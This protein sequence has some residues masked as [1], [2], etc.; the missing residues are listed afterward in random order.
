MATFLNSL[1]KKKAK[2]A[3]EEQYGRIASDVQA[4]KMARIALENKGDVDVQALENKGAVDVTNLQ[5]TGSTLRTNITDT[6]NTLRRNLAE[7]G[8]TQRTGMNL[9]EDARQFDKDYGLNVKKDT[10]E[11][12]QFDLEQAQAEY[13]DPFERE[14]RRSQLEAEVPA[15][16]YSGRQSY[17]E[18]DEMDAEEAAFRETSLRAT[19]AR[20]LE[21]D[22]EIA[23][24]NAFAEEL[25][26]QDLVRQKRKKSEDYLGTIF[27]G[28]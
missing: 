27:G 2:M 3:A 19:A 20:R 25:G 23:A 21:R 12:R 13:I 5:E 1:A 7:A 14:S 22:Q 4:A 17:R 15:A 18:L 11:Q 24:Q 10:R 8:E 6:G 26:R 9:A 16:R 28:Y